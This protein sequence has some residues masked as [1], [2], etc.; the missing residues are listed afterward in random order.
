MKQLAH[1]N[2]IGMKETSP[3]LITEPS[4]PEIS[5]IRAFHP[6]R[7]SGLCLDDTTAELPV[8]NSNQ[9]T[10]KVSRSRQGY[11]DA[12]LGSMESSPDVRRGVMRRS[13]KYFI[14]MNSPKPIR[15]NISHGDRQRGFDISDSVAGISDSSKSKLPW[16]N[17]PKR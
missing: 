2:H 6:I 10:T 8:I 7:R 13:G 4:S 14:G 1:T 17:E 11:Q 9:A 12:S 5:E 3:P 16:H 15:G